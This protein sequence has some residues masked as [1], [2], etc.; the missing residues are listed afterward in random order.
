[1]AQKNSLPV[2]L[3]TW[4][5]LLVRQQFITSAALIAWNVWSGKSTLA[6]TYSG[7][8]KLYTVHYIAPKRKASSVLFKVCIQLGRRIAA[9]HR[10]HLP[11]GKETSG[12]S[13]MNEEKEAETGC[14][15]VMCR[16]A[17]QASKTGSCSRF[18]S[19]QIQITMHS[20]L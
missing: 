16:C 2:L 3:L 5:W 17:D 13:K 8:R 1:M 20:H 11:G 6:Q 12:N 10:K 7:K 18:T 15:L 4:N 19:Q 9:W 14:W